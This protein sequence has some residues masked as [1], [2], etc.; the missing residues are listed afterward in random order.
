MYRIITSCCFICLIFTTAMGKRVPYS[1]AQLVATSFFQTM[2][3]PQLKS[4]SVSDLIPVSLSLP[5]E[6]RFPIQKSQK[7][8]EDQLVYFFKKNE[9]GFVLVSGDDLAKPILAYSVEEIV[10]EDNLPVNFLK[11][12]DGYKK[13]IR[14]IRQ[15]P[16]LKSTSATS[17]WEQLEAGMKPEQL[18][19]TA[20]GPLMKTKWD[21]SPLY[22]DLC[23][24]KYWY[25]NKAVTGCVATAMAQVIKYHNY[26]VNGTG[27]HSYYHSN[28]TVTYGTLSANY[29]AT[30]YDWA[31][32]PNQLNS[33]STASQIK[34]VA[35]LML[36]CG[37]GVDMDYSP[38]SSGAQILES[39]SAGSSCAESALKEFFNFDKTTVKGVLREGKTT[40][41]WI[42]LLKSEIDAGRPILHG[43][44]GDGGGHAF[45]ADGYDSNNYFHFNWGW[46]G[47]SDG[48]YS[49]DA[50]NPVDLGTGAGN[51]SYNR[52]QQVV[53]GIKPPSQGS[54]T[55]TTKIEDISLYASLKLPKIYQLNEFQFEVSIANY[56][57]GNFNGNFC[58][59]LFNSEG[60]FVNYIDSLDA[61]VNLPSNF[62]NSYQ[63]SNNGLSVYPGKYIVGIYFRPTGNNWI[64]VGDGSYENFINI[65]ILSPFGDTDIK[66]YDS[67]R[68][69]PNP[70]IAGKSTEVTAK[71]ANYGYS[72][73][74][75]QFGA[76]LFKLNGDIVQTF[77]IIDVTLSKQYW[78]LFTFSEEKIEAEPGTYYLG[79]V[80]FPNSGD[81]QVVIAP[82]EFLNPVE[83]NVTIPPLLPDNFES[84]DNVSSASDIL[85]EFQQ[86]VHWYYYTGL[87]IDNQKDE[88]YFKF[89]L[90]TGYQYKI[91]A[92]VHDAYDNEIEDEEYSCDVIFAHSEEGEWSEVFDTEMDGTYTL[93]NGG[94]LYFGVIPYYEGETGTYSIEFK[95][96]RLKGSEI[97]HLEFPEKV[98]IFP[99]PAKQR[100]HIESIDPIIQ[101]ELIDPTGRV[102]Y[103]QPGFN[104]RK[105]QIETT[106]LS[107]GIYQIRIK[108]P[109]TVQTQKIVLYE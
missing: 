95:I 45:V 69:S 5:G 43:G 61:F 14:W 85:L 32:M 79:M 98:R 29:G 77:E 36:H 31:N 78:Q 28:N 76:G 81:D 97:A 25:S 18:S 101:L 99:N 94:D 2:D 37:V 80:H 58:A 47:N 75:G 51:G 10:N 41:Q 54:G 55:S 9:G 15:Q 93:Y 34:A 100:L 104:S 91:W 53:I 65:E 71:I 38:Y 109:E 96:E 108:Y 4:I 42:S 107:R 3:D 57:T 90:P 88:D 16:G 12:V 17:E 21:Q 103:R 26:P 56:G 33:A 70:I 92:R 105:T 86:D 8:K 49:V 72:E 48:Y 102:V 60:K 66:L 27:I 1:R 44:V 83:V 50:L 46:S 62:Y 84:N 67:I 35:T 59:A 30:T 87:N 22:N 39:K 40:S 52:L 73:Y 63:F 24:Q 82:G 7:S 11:W 64:A 68:V 13:E 106:G 19:G 74:R 23:P 6:N 20:V 89:N